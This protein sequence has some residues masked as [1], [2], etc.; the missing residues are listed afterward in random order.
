MKVRTVVVA[1]LAAA[2]SAPAAWSQAPAPAT[3]ATRPEDRLPTTA[4][5]DVPGGRLAWQRLPDLPDALGVAGPFVGGHRG[6][7]VVAGGANFPT[8]AGE[9]RWTA[10]KVWHDDVWVLAEDEAGRP[11]WLDQPPLARAMGYGA[12]AS[13]PQG[14]VCIGGEDGSEVFDTVT[15]LSWNPAARRLDVHPLP[16]LPQPTCFSGAGTIGSTVY[17]ACGQ[18]GPDRL[19]AA[20]TVYRLD[21][22]GFDPA[23]GRDGATPPAWERLP[24]VPGGPRTA[25]VVGVRHGPDGPRLFVISGRRPDPANGAAAIEMLRDAHEF[26]PAAWEASGRGL[27]STA[28]WRRLADVPA[29]RMAGT[30]LPLSAT[31]VAILSGDDG[32]LYTRTN[33]LK[34]SHPG[35][36][37]ACLV[38]D[39]VADAWQVTGETPTG[40]LAT[41]IVPWNG[42]WAMISGE[43]RPRVRTP[44][45]WWITPT[46]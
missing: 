26:D 39:A 28:G 32:R 23:A 29:P 21:L 9:D 37:L 12:T 2:L 3:A 6:A 7:V 1:M 4:T 46:P 8:A 44:A 25:P 16:P 20:A 17:V 41:T 31:H 13:T 5:T 36:P 43:V 34:E 14:V 45:A 11:E 22:A 33:V 19:T 30:C 42:G 38:Y 15:L 40:Q 10:A 24:D 35:F 27:G 18:H